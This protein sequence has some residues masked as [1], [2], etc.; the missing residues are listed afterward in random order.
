MLH[1]TR[2]WQIKDKNLPLLP[3]GFLKFYQHLP[4]R[5]E[6][7][8][9]SKETFYGAFLHYRWLIK[10][11]INIKRDTTL[12]RDLKRISATET[13]QERTLAQKW[14]ITQRKTFY[15]ALKVVE[16]EMGKMHL[17]NLLGYESVDTP[18]KLEAKTD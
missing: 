7:S 2:A 1:F 15:E 13:K 4:E 8:E 12:F 14:A 16:R 18:N 11:S 9:E 3:Q 17:L 5:S 10:N 6:G